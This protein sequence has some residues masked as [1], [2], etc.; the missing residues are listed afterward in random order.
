[1]S[2]NPL[3]GLF[4][5]ALG[6]VA[7]ASFYAPLKFIRRWPW[8]CFYLA[9]GF[10]SWLCTPWIFAAASTPDLWNVVTGAPPAALGLTFLFGLLWGVGAVTFGLSMRYLGMALG[11][12]IA[13]G[14][15]ALFG[16]LVPPIVQGEL[17]TV[18]STRSGQVVLAGIAL[19]A[20]GILVSGFAGMRKEREIVKEAHTGDHSGDDEFAPIKG[21]IVA[22]ICGLM[23]ACFAFGLQSGAP[24]AARAV[25]VGVNPLF[26]NNAVLCVIL[27]GGFI[28]N[29]LWCLHLNRKNRTF[30]EYRSANL[31][32][33]TGILAL[34]ALAGVIWYFQ[35][36]F[37]GMGATKMGEYEFSSWSLHMAFIIICGN[38]W[39]LGFREWKGVSGK[40]LATVWAGILILIASTAIIGWGNALGEVTTGH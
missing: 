5:H 19:C 27:A 20:V 17:A 36:F 13:L 37:Y 25:E 6:G 35:F 3:L 38:L 7:A 8:E 2:P 12:S 33:T 14:F 39:G 15:C 24:I 10:F 32:Q 34:C 30:K 40:T 21:L 23:S 9:M 1:M 26:Q 31:P 18:A 28:T 11:M 4:F 22:L 29:T 16:T